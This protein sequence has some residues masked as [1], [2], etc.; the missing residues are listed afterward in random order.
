LIEWRY[1]HPCRRASSVGHDQWF[2]VALTAE[3]RGAFAVCGTHTEAVAEV[4]D[5]LGLSKAR[6]IGGR[7]A[8]SPTEP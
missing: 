3:N 6:I 7:Y 8:K 1:R 2:C 5:D 4:C